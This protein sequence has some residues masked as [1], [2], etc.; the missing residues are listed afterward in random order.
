MT[1]ESESN[2]SKCMKYGCSDF[3]IASRFMREFLIQRAEIIFP[4]R[5]RVRK[6]NVNKNVRDHIIKYKFVEMFSTKLKVRKVVS[7]IFFLFFFKKWL[8][9]KEN[10]GRSLK[11]IIM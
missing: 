2:K 11:F 7:V 8:Y 3:N 5:K 9:P 10:Y 6:R 1:C 4:E